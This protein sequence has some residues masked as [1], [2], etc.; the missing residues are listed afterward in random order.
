MKKDFIDFLL[1][2]H[3]KEDRGSLAKLRRGVGKPPGESMEV[4]SVIG[5]FIAEAKSE[6]EEYALY[7]VA[8]LYGLYPSESAEKYNFGA[9]FAQL[10]LRQES[11]STERRFV[12]ILNSNFED[13]PQH[14]RQA[15]NLLKSKEVHINWL[16]LL[17]DILDWQRDD[18]KV[19]RQWATSFWKEIE[20]EETRQAEKTEE[21]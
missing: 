6:L 3:K 4:Y 2:L 13:L 5:R 14:L 1:E 20:T 11:E 15:V 9:S 8:T 19:Q 10:R 12:A 18:Y 7:L 16:Q 21:I 17:N